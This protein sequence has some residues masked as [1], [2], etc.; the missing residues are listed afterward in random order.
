MAGEGW[1]NLGIVGR[2]YS[3]A[4][5]AVCFSCRVLNASRW[6][7][8]LA[9]ALAADSH[10][11]RIYDEADGSSLVVVDQPDLTN[12]NGFKSQLEDWPFSWAEPD[13]PRPCVLR[14]AEGSQGI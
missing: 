10:T 5:Y 14:R 6:R 13:R 8:E 7:A 1:P 12:A 11:F 3:G 4:L 2:C 9:L